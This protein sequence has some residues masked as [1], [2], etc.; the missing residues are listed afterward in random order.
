MTGGARRERIATVSWPW[1]CV[2]H[3]RNFRGCS[4]II[5]ELESAQGNGAARAAVIVA[6]ETQRGEG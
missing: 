5:L 1:G 3:L 2:G 4:Q 6:S